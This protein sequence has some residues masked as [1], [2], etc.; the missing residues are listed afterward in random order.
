MN[1]LFPVSYILDPVEDDKNLYHDLICSYC[2]EDAKSAPSSE[3]S[4]PAEQGS[5]FS[6]HQGMKSPCF[7]ENILFMVPN[8]L[9]LNLYEG[10]DLIFFIMHTLKIYIYTLL[11]P[12]Q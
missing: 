6:E 12:R 10:Q 9:D 5:Y 3:L 8:T 2:L 11:H 7:Q 1:C 4:E